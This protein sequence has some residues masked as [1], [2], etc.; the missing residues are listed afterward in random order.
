MLPQISVAF[1]PPVFLCSRIPS[2]IPY[3][4]PQVSFGSPCLWQFLIDFSCFL[5]LGQFG[6][7]LVRCCRVPLN[8]GLADVLLM[9]RLGL[10]VWG[11]ENPGA[12]S[13]FQPI[14]SKGACCLC[15]V[16]LGI[17]TEAVLVRCLYC[18][19]TLSFS[20]SHLC[21]WE[22]GSTRVRSR[23]PCST[24]SGQGRGPTYSV[25]NS[26]AQ[27]L[28][29]FSPGIHLSSLFT[30]ISVDQW[31]F[32]LVLQS[33]TTLLYGSDCS[34]FGHLESFQLV[35]AS[36]CHA[37]LLWVNVFLFLH[38]SLVFHCKSTP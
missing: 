1:L 18:E 34:S 16:D 25:W 29:L 9:V 10:C 27:E 35:P 6:G 7:V 22:E 12:K 17:L 15:D 19:V 24:S 20:P 13:R 38:S 36:L 21:S 28:C 30:Y 8:W 14:V 2:R 33:N 31:V 23:G 26:A 32:I 3:F 37:L 4:S 5:W 11:R